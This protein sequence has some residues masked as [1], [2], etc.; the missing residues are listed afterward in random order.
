MRNISV[1]DALSAKRFLKVRPM[2]NQLQAASH[3]RA[4]AV[5]WALVPFHSAPFSLD[6]RAVTL[7]Y[8]TEWEP[9]N[10]IGGK[11]MEMKH[12]PRGGRLSNREGRMRRGGAEEERIEGATVRQRK[13]KEKAALRLDCRVQTILRGVCDR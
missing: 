7:I 10:R 13:I 8:L 2:S 12:E 5:Y 9:L 6:S 3:L 11:T 1:S 4:S